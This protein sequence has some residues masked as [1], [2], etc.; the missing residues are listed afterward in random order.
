MSAEIHLVEFN[1]QCREAADN[2]FLKLRM[3]SSSLTSTSFSWFTHLPPNSIQKWKDMQTKYLLHFT[4]IQ[5]GVNIGDLAKIVQEKRKATGD[6]IQRFKNT[7]IR[8]HLNI[9]ESEF[10]FIVPKVLSFPFRKKFGGQ[11]FP[12]FVAL[13]SAVMAYE[14]CLEEESRSKHK[15]Y[16]SMA[17]EYNREDDMYEAAIAEFVQGLSFKCPP[18]NNKNFTYKKDL[19]SDRKRE[20][21]FDIR[22]FD[23]IFYWLLSHKKIKLSGRH[24]TRSPNEV[25][26]NNYYKWHDVVTH[27]TSDCIILRNKIQDEIDK[28]HIIFPNEKVSSCEVESESA[29]KSEVYEMNCFM[30]SADVDIVQDA[31]QRLKWRRLL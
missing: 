30:V 28:K 31:I 25:K 9:L 18:L 8:C 14:R 6:Y 1:C 11:Y 7:K 23:E 16:A 4:R 12:D 22:R 20:Y 26:G 3:F 21:T 24:K 15:Y 13:S 2:E 10:V 19:R 29:S 17:E 27:K 5:A